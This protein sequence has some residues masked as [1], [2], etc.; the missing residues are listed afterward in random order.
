MLRW[1]KLRA[2]MSG[3]SH[4]TARVPVRKVSGDA[5]FSRAQLDVLAV[6]E[7]H[8]DDMADLLEGRE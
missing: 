4:G 1:A 2:V 7:E 5:G 8:A 3:V 6:E